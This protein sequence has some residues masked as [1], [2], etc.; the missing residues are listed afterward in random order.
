MLYNTFPSLRNLL[1]AIGILILLANLPIFPG[2]TRPLC[3]TM[4]QLYGL[5]QYSYW[6]SCAHRL[7]NHQPFSTHPRK[8]LLRTPGANRRQVLWVNALEYFFLGSLSSLSGVLQA[9][10]RFAFRIPFLIDFVAMLVAI[11]IGML[12]SRRVLKKSPL[13]VLRNEV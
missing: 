11:F 3:I 2:N 13:E 9:L 4:N 8:C 10:A 7:S 6:I 1:E 12:N 5:V